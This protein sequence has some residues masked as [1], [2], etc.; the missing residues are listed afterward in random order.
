MLLDSSKEPS[1]VNTKL[2]ISDDEGRV[3]PATQHRDTEIL[4]LPAAE[5]K[6]ASGSDSTKQ[7]QNSQAEVCVHPRPTTLTRDVNAQILIWF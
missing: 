7:S 1:M 3:P 4:K 6:A 2:D 5:Q